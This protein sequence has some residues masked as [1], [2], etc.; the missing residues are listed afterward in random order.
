MRV[1]FFAS[2]AQSNYAAS[3]L[4]RLRKAHAGLKWQ[5]TE[6]FVPQDRS[7][8]APNAPSSLISVA[9]PEFA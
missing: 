5:N 9:Q 1:N 3:G 2:G 8:L 6:A 4:P 7:F